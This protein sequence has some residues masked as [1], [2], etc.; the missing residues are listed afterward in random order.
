MIKQRQA[1]HLSEA[2]R[3]AGFTQRTLAARS[4]IPQPTIAAIEAGRRQ[5]RYDTLE[6]LLRAC[7]FDLELAPRKG[8]GVDR[9]LIVEMLRLSPVE[10][11]R[12]AGREINALAP[13]DRAA[14][15]MRAE[16]RR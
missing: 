16:A 4:G 15:R 2:R 13:F 1:T 9:S 8:V 11:I 6:R 12:L 3:R 10:R 5:P 14:A 7:G